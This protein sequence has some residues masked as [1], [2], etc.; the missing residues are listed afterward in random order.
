LQLTARRL[1]VAAYI[2]IPE[3]NQ[4]KAIGK[5]LLGVGDLAGVVYQSA[6]RNGSLRK[7]PLCEVIHFDQHG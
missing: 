3:F 2:L 5:R 1:P 7:T 4:S 6:G